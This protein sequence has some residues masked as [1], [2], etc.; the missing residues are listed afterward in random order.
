MDPEYPDGG[1]RKQ[2]NDVTDFKTYYKPT[3]IELMR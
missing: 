1:R 2:Q 3:V